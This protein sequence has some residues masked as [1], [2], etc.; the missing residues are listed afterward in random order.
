M[1]GLLLLKELKW[2]TTGMLIDLLVFTVMLVEE[3]E[4]KLFIVLMMIQI[5][6]L[7]SISL[8]KYKPIWLVM[9]HLTI[10]VV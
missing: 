8:K 6:L 4:L 5:L 9:V 1:V 3:L 2:Q 10:D 7:I